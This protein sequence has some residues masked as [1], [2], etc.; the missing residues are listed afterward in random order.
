M[1]DLGGP[2][3]V[4]G[5]SWAILE[6]VLRASWAFLE[7]SWGATLTHLGASWDLLESSWGLLVIFLCTFYLDGVL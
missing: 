3:E 5:W 4:L 6:G 2:W 7:A 1:V